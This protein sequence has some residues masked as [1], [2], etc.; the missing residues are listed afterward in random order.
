MDIDIEKK[1]GERSFDGKLKRAYAKGFSDGKEYQAKQKLDSVEQ[2]QVEEV[3]THRKVIQKYV[4]LVSIL[5]TV[6][7]VCVFGIF[8]LL[9]LRGIMKIYCFRFKRF[10]L[11]PK[12]S[13]KYYSCKD[14]PPVSKVWV[15]DVFYYRIEIEI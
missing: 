3:R 5:Y 10:Y 4:R 7:T 8:I 13:V 12:F 9:V 15:V 11:L 1:L 2:V 14:F 6:M